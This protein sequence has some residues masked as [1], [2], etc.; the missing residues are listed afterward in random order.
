MMCSAFA[1][2]GAI[3]AC[4]SL[5]ALGAMP[6]SPAHAARQSKADGSYRVAARQASPDQRTPVPGA[7]A[8]EREQRL[9]Q[10]GMTAGS[11]VMVRIF[12]AESEFELWLRKDGRFELFATYPICFWSGTLGPK[13][14]EGD[15]Q[16]P[17]GLYSVG[18]RQLHREGQRPRSFDIGFPNS[19][20]RAEA[21]T[22]SYILVHGGCKSTGCYAMTDPVMDEI[23][24]L[25]DQAL[26]QGQERVQV[27][28]FPF[29]MN[30]A[31]LAL[32]ADSRWIGFWHNLKDA[33]D[34]FERTRVPPK[35]SVCN[36]RYVV[37]E[38]AVPANDQASDVATPAADCPEEKSVPVL[39][40]QAGDGNAKTAS[41]A[42][43]RS[44]SAKA[45][46][47]RK[48]AKGRERSRGAAGR[49]NVR[50]AQA[51]ARQT[52]VAAYMRRTAAASAAPAPA[53]AP[54]SMPEPWE[55]SQR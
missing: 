10:K 37:G 44:V 9:Q 18:Y 16:A 15:K 5:V 4:A 40:V 52:R 54:P 41:V 31:N 51:A 34:V 19:F 49:S 2:K 11:P 24:A 33:Y 27:H 17:E 13:L 47:H 29:R 32:H 48:E 50:R 23:Y 8:A 3:L 45:A 6:T 12:K 38:G 46:K 22:G 7:A 25:V 42:P 36:K 20:D 26:S 21:R 28:V 43:T 39:S 53:P 35:V 1:P 14:R 30:D 55:R